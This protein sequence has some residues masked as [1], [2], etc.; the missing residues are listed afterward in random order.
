MERAKVSTDAD[1]GRQQGRAD[2]PTANMVHATAIASADRAILIRGPSGS[3]KSDLALRCLMRAAG[4]VGDS[5]ASPRCQLVGDDYV[6]IAE[7]DGA[8]IVSPAP[9]L[10]GK[11][12]VRGMGILI[13]P[14]VREARVT[15]IADLVANDSIDRLPS[16][17]PMETILGV[18]IPVFQICGF[19]ASAP[20][21]LLLAL[22]TDAADW[23]HV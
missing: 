9:A 22:C 17:R 2:S 13:V 8:L 5:P 12:E 15:A 14:F 7:R 23:D 4:P 11:L 16:P 10:S 3:G 1:Q 6:S 20:D 21:K 19:D 18:E